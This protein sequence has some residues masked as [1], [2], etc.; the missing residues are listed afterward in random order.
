MSS[1][2]TGRG[3]KRTSKRPLLDVITENPEGIT[4]EDLLREANYKIEEVGAFYRELASIMAQVEEIKPT[5]A[6]AQAWP[7]K[8]HVLLKPQKV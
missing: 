2:S 7:V 4:P 8:A 6:Q 3:R 1:K 5:G